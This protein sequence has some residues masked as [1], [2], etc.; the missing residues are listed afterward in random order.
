MRLLLLLFIAC[1][2]SLPAQT[3]FEQWDQNKDVKLSRDELPEAARN[4]F[5]KA[6]RDGDGFISAKEDAAM[7]QQGNS[8]APAL[9]KG[10]ERRSDLDYVGDGNPR[11]M[12]DLYFPK[13]RTSEKPLP[14]VVW[15]H[16][17]AWRSG[18]KEYA[19]LLGEVVA[20]GEFIGASINY[21]LS[22]EAIWPAQITTAKRRFVG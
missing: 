5:A 15:I 18:S 6:D 8:A 10:V 20:T 17:G 4:N 13:Q 11:Q 22:A 7:R 2:V 16:G 9:P 19:R 21:R 14:L 3:R 12:L 1:T